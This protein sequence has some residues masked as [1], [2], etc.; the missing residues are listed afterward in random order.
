MRSTIAP[1]ES[2]ALAWAWRRSVKCST[3]KRI[4][5][6]IERN[7]AARIGLPKFLS[8]SLLSEIPKI[9]TGIVPTI[10]RIKSGRPDPAVDLFRQPLH[11]EVRICSHLRPKTRKS[12]MALAKWNAT[13]INRYWGSCAKDFQL[14]PSHA[15][16][17]TACP[18]LETGKSS[19]TPC[20]SP[21][22]I[23]C[24]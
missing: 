21:T 16:S 15:G 9:A 11:A 22:T 20:R 18:K 23:P 14:P 24:R 6:L 13:A 8:K 7:I 5:P 3:P 19:V 4:K 2:F 17:N 1:S 10:S 12:A